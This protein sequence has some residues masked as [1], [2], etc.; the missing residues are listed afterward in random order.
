MSVENETRVLIEEI[1]KTRAVLDR[2][3]RHY[4]EFLETDFPGLGKKNASAVV[5]ADTLVNT[6]TCMETVFLRIS[7]FFE[8]D[9]HR[10]KWYAD[11]LHKMTLQIEGIR[12]AVISEKVHAILTE[13][14]K[15]RHFK[16][17]YFNVEYDWDR[18]EYL[19]KK[20]EQVLPLVEYDLD[21]FTTFLRELTGASR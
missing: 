19:Q 10:K 6:Y 7:Q 21:R 17:Y 20:Y 2:I 14:L 8:N 12:R 1:N 13:L 9:L 5:I 3:N 11:L 15:F 4:R 16:R 18:I